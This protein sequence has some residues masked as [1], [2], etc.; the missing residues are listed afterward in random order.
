MSERLSCP[1]CGFQ[2]TGPTCTNCGYDLVQGAEMPPVAKS[3]G[4][5]RVALAFGLVGIVI[6]I[7][8]VLALQ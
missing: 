8:L 1:T 5:N 6:R 2:R 3:P 7:V 4:I